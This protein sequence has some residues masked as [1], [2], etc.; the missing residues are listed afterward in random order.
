[1]NWKVVLMSAGC[2]MAV[3]N[4]CIDPEFW[5]NVYV[6]VAFLGVLILDIIEEIKKKE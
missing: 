6:A 2:T 5:K 1:M 4:C 3:I